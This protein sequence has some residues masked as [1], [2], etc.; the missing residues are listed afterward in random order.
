M[1]PAIT[2]RPSLPAGHRVLGFAEIER[3]LHADASVEVYRLKGAPEQVLVHIRNEAE[4][5]DLAA[6]RL[7]PWWKT[8]ASS[9]VINEVSSGSGAFEAVLTVNGAW[10]G[11]PVEDGAPPAEEGE[12]IALLTGLCDSGSLA[13]TGGTEPLLVPSLVWWNRSDGGRAA[14]LYLRRDTADEARMVRSAATLVYERASG[15]DLTATQG[16]VPPLSK[17]VKSAGSTITITLARCLSV[18]RDSLRTTQDVKAALQMRV[19]GPNGPIAPPTEGSVPRAGQ[20]LAG[21]AGMRELRSLLEREVV[22]PIRNPGP[23]KKYGLTIPNGILL[24]GPPGCGKTWIAR[25]LAEEVG[26]FFVEIIPSEIASPYIHGSVLRIR[27]LFDTAVERA[28][29]IIFIDEFEALV[30]SRAELGGFQQHKSEEVNEF[31]AHLN[32]C[33]EKQVFII[34]ATNEPQK[35][36]PAVRRT[37]RFDKLIYVGPPDA[38][39]RAEMLRMHLSGRPVSA[40]LDYRGIAAALGGYAASDIKFLVDQAARAAMEKSTEI[41]GEILLAASQTVPPSVTP[42]IESR[43]K[44]FVERG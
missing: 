34:A 27:E 36:D 29:S 25:K 7:V 31:L 39:A 16:L 32:A 24:Y 6:A 42:E 41:S 40:T 13:L 44:R 9:L 12:W 26:H 37:G 8:L 30:P 17:W 2:R 19:A 23:S 22:Q 18:G 28:P 43:F 1:T 21:V 35:I 14:P 10:L 5:R 38:E 15:I 3:P 11:H 20:G 4:P 33:A